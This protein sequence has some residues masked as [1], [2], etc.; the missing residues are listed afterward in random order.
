MP[1]TPRELLQGLRA[2][3]GGK[4]V[5]ADEALALVQDGDTVATSGFVGIGFAE[6]LALALERRFLA[7]GHPRDLR[8]VYAA[9]QGDGAER[10]LNHLGHEGLV[11]G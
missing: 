7:T 5:T 6:G 10:G 1:Q 9:G 8:L 11:A 2:Y 3:E 4:L